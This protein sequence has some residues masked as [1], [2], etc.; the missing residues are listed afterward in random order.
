MNCAV[1]YLVLARFTQR[2]NRTTSASTHAIETR[3]GLA[4]THRIKRSLF[5]SPEYKT[6][7]KVHTTL[8]ELV[9][10]PPFT[11]KR[12]EKS[13]E[14][15]SFEALRGTLRFEDE[16]SSF[17]AALREAASIGVRS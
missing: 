2:D 14:A 10:T 3:T 5:D 12:G 13:D 1:A 9:G 6:F 8:V 16:P 4:Q 7:V 15:L 11:V 17:E